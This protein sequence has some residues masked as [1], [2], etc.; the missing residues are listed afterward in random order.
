MHVLVADSLPPEII[1]SLESLG[2]RVTHAPDADLA[3]A[4]READVLVV[5]RSRVTRRVVESGQRLKAILRA[6][7]GVD[8][9]DVPAASERGIAVAHCP[10][11]HVHARAEHVLGL[12]LALDRGLGRGVSGAA[13]SLGLRGRTLGLVGFD[14]TARTLAPAATALGMRI[15]VWDPALTPALAAEAG[16]HRAESVDS[17]FARADVVSLHP[18][19][20]V[21]AGV[22]ATAERLGRLAA[23][24]SLVNI[25]ARGLVDLA[26]AKTA[27][28]A[29]GL[30]LALDVY[31]ADDYGD[32][33]PFAADAYPGLVVTFRQAGRTREADDAVAHAVVRALE[34][35]LSRR[36][37]PDAANEATSA[38]RGHVVVRHSADPGVL[39]AIFEALREHGAA[40]VTL[41]G[42]GFEGGHAGLLRVEV[43][44]AVPPSL[45]AELEGIS[46]VLG[47][48]AR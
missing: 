24:A 47:V 7:V 48:E 32:D 33:V 27:L 22:L 35:F 43:G 8:T 11:A 28:D 13:A 21:A 15:L 17:V 36:E 41:S 39:P 38:A 31:D 18:R 9:I 5:S 30:R 40:V 14:A 29:G 10:D 45:V 46:G 20:G 2:Y 44:A 42:H 37:L 16:V 19:D 1:S 4:V 12:V 26:A 3:T 6:G 23:G 34:L 25:T